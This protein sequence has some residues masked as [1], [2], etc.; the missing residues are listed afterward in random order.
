M[1]LFPVWTRLFSCVLYQLCNCG[2]GF[3]CLPGRSDGEEVVV[4]NKFM[5][6]NYPILV[7]PC[8][9]LV[10]V[11]MLIIRLPNRLLTLIVLQPF[12]SLILL[13]C[14]WCWLPV[15]GRLATRGENHSMLGMQ[16]W[17][18]ELIHCSIYA[19][20][21]VGYSCQ[22]LED[23]VR[24]LLAWKKTSCSY[25]QTNCCWA[26]FCLTVCYLRSSI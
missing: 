7:L 23:H 25:Q 26:F 21:L 20:R 10:H 12:V 1:L 17:S 11:M 2:V 24:F 19:W 13:A 16:E 18:C 14:T 15:P 3:S 5:R 9:F 22:Q 8:A 6:D 4:D